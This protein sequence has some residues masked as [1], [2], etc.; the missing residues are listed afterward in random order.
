[1]GQHG[2]LVA[3]PSVAWCFDTIYYFERAAETY[4]TALSTGRPLAVASDQVAEKT[5]R[6]WEGYP[7]FADKH[8]A[9]I[10][11]ILTESEP[12]YLD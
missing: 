3:G 6:Q 4:F 9:A 10:H 1:M 7:G 8:L 5:A 12:A 2:I 11:S